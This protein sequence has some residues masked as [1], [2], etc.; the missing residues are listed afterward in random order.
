MESSCEFNFFENKFS[1]VKIK[2]IEELLGKEIEKSNGSKS[3]KR[4]IKILH[5][6]SVLVC[7][8][9]RNLT[10]LL[11]NAEF[12]TTKFQSFVGDENDYQN[13]LL[14]L[15]NFIKHNIKELAMDIDSSSPWFEKFVLRAKTENDEL[16][17]IIK[18]ARTLPQSMGKNPYFE[19]LLWLNHP[20]LGLETFRKVDSLMKMSNSSFIKFSKKLGV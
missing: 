5:D 15:L 18:S 20:F 10:I 19:Q 12:H 7:S 3:C 4:L 9:W 17:F 14:K 1:E 13:C 2:R 6:S 11:D 16:A 8:E